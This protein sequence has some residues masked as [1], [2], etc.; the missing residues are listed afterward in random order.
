[1]TRIPR[2]VQ[3]RV[4]EQADNRCG[5]C[6]SPQKYV[7][8]VLE[9][10]HIFPQAKGGSSDESNLWLACRL[11]NSFKG[12][13]TYIADPITKQRVR[14]FNPRRQKWQ[15]HFSWSAD[16]LRIIG[17]TICGRATV[18]ALQLNNPIA[19]MVRRSWASVGWTPLE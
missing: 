19:L 12:T 11:C 7:W 16:Y 3:R 2:P 18:E 6:R 8:G 10:E 4:R 1:M 5:Y 17:K 14:L 15:K 13:Q 9:I